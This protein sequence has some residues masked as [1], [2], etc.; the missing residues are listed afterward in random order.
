MKNLAIIL[1]RSGSKG[2]INK[3]IKLLDGKP[4]MAYSIESARQ[5]GIFDT[6]HVSTD[7]E[8]YKKIAE[9]YG[10]DEPFLRD[11]ELAKDNITLRETVLGVLE[12]Y[13]KVGKKFDNVMVLQPTSPLRDA[14][15]VVGA[16]KLFVKKGAKA[17]ISVCECE[18]PP[19]WCN[20][21]APDYNMDAFIHE[22]NIRPRQ[23]LPIYYRVNGAIYL[24]STEY[25]RKTERIYTS[26]TYA[27]VMDK[28]KSVD[29]DDILD[30]KMAELYLKEN[31]KQ[32]G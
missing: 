4:L 26:S 6:I 13:E 3:N 9:K 24:Y 31:K 32:N 29:I 11:S 2:L 27:Y 23:E 7:S 19:V 1:A 25:I 8:E 12:Q 22:E 17:V 16:Y 15:D 28:N 30:F 20:T 10:A 18:Y 21:L 5:S 14:A